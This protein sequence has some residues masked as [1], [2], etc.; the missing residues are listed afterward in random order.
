MI[1]SRD[2]LERRIESFLSRKFKEFPELEES[3]LP[4]RSFTS[5]KPHQLGL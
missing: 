5:F 1:A 4:V 3:E 2:K